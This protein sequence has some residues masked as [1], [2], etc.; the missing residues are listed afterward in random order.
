MHMQQ[1][2]RQIVE[3]VIYHGEASAFLFNKT[4]WSVISYHII[5]LFTENK[6]L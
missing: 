2:Q 3:L 1:Q 5:Y 4:S 6:T